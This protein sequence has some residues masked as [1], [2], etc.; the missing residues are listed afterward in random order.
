MSSRAPLR[1]WGWMAVWGWAC[2]LGS[3]WA[4]ARASPWGWGGDYPLERG[5]GSPV[6]WGQIWCLVQFQWAGAGWRPAGWPAR[7]AGPAGGRGCRAQ[8]A[9]PGRRPGAGSTWCPVEA[10]LSAWP[11]LAR[12]GSWGWAEGRPVEGGRVRA[13]RRCDK[14]RA[15]Q[16]W[17]GC[18][19]R[20]GA[21][22]AGEAG[23]TS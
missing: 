14:L 7:G 1:R 4:C 12:S 16:R 13:E 20:R 3:P 10:C 22:G 15:P 19:P 18:R 9:G 2:P 21:R 17:P 23:Q 8:G 11:C 5:E 6:L